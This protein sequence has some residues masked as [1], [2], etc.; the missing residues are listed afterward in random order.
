M[1][2]GRIFE[3][4]YTAHFSG[5]ETFPMRYGWLKKAFDRVS[6]FP[7][8][9]SNR[10]T[11]WGDETIAHYGVGK[12][13]VTSMRYWAKAA[14]VIGEVENGRIAE[15]TR[16]G[17]MIFS[18]D[19][20]DP[21]MENAATLWL[22]H[23]ALASDS[24]RT[25]WY[26][27]FGHFSGQA[28][29]VDELT[30]RLLMLAEEQEWPRASAATVKNDVKCFVRTYAA[31][32]FKDTCDDDLLESPLT[33]L[34]LIRSAGTSGNY[35]FSRG[36]KS[37]LGSG[38]FAYALIDFWDCYSKGST[39]SF[40]AIAHEPG[41]PGRSF[42]LEENDVID[43]LVDI[44]LATNGALSW[45]ETAGLKQVIRTRDIDEEMRHSWIEGDFAEPTLRD[46]TY[47]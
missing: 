47:A 34:G 39:L 46:V 12:N 7:S 3:K 2:R 29:D 22:C 30:R 11:C 42:L 38:V 45:S 36:P 19:G 17:R 23:W 14:G 6:A 27:S 26:W 43:R 37:S 10:D 32:S 1:T 8:D 4:D 31:K 13:M 24:R 28:F 40:E 33:E 44:D 5:H 25:T 15:P 9:S 21:F 35:R 41:G 18:D 16:L 20:L